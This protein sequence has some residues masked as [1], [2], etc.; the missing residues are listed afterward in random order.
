MRAATLDEAIDIVNE[1]DYGLTSG[2]HSLDPAEIGT[3]LSR[4]D[5]GNLY[6]NRGITG[7][8]VRRQPFGGWKKSAVGA[9]T[10]AGGVNY[11]F[12]LGSWAPAAA[13]AGAPVSAPVS[14][15]VRAS[16]I[17]SASLS[18]A[19]AS[20]EL[21]WTSLF[22]VAT[23]VSALAA[24]RNIARYLP[25]PGVHVRSASDSPDDVESLV[26]VVAA[27][28]RAGTTIDVSSAGTVPSAI[29][30]LGSVRSVTSGESDAAFGAR[31]AAGPSTRVRLIGGS[32]SALYEAVDGR[33]D[34]AVYAEPVTEAGRI[35]MLPFLREQAVSIT[36]HRFGTPNHLWKAIGPVRLG[37]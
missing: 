33:P 30:A 31:V 27:A 37:A 18:R 19:I 10:K 24:E 4:I 29:A 25:Y 7:A 14:S 2:L 26:R 21:A 9:G 6:V 36:A 28:L 32:A 5:A 16:G 23:D 17:S 8:I 12:G 3:W 35:E 1:V 13:T 22:G 20:D 15:F 34:V 11:L